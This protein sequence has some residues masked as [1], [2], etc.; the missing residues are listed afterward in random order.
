MGLNFEDKVDRIISRLI[1]DELS[2]ANRHVRNSPSI[3]R[4]SDEK[5]YPE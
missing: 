2:E 3:A 4:I 5:S 1:L